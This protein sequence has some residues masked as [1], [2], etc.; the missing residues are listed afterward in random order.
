MKRIFVVVVV[1]CSVWIL[2]VQASLRTRINAII[3]SKDK[4]RFG[5]RILEARTGRAVYSHNDKTPLI[6][7]SNMK[8]VTSAAALHFLGADFNYITRVGMVGHT[9]VV[10][11]SGDPLLGDQSTDQALGRSEGW[12]FEDLASL[13]QNAQIERLDSVIV[14]STVFDDERVHPSWPAAELNRDYSCEVCGIN[15]NGNAISMKVTKQGNRVDV[16]I[17]PQ[18]SFVTIRNE[19]RP[20]ASGSGAV[21]AYRN[22]G[23]SN[24]LTVKGRCRKQQGPFNVAIE[25]PAAFLGYL[26]AEQLGARGIEC[27]GQL[28]EMAFVPDKTYRPLASYKTP[29]TLCLKRCNTDSFNLAAECLAKTIGAQANGG[30]NGSWAMAR[31][32]IGQYL[33][34]LGLD[35]DEYVLDDASGLSRENRLSA[36]VLSTVLYSVYTSA[37]W[38]LYKDTF[39][40]GGVEGTLDDDFR[41]ARYKA[42]ILGKTGYINRVRAFSGVC[43]TDQGDYL[44]SILAND[45]NSIKTLVNQIAKAVMDEYRQE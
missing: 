7:A 22:P 31:K 35:P 14:D 34:G 27:S 37:N 5:I 44:F 10:I 28:L 15:Y 32:R 38:S 30:R 41:Q 42:R 17:E 9:L 33:E 29:L 18:T 19:V 24:V 43:Q 12:L 36:R 13:L 2:P 40:V 8:I 11:G 25:K 4:I 16:G 26:L 39:A 23:S 45:A 6:P 3:Q 1:L 21:G 20:I